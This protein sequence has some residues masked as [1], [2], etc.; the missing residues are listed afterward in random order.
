MATETSKPV[1]D[2]EPPSIDEEGASLP[3]LLTDEFLTRFER[4]VENYK[5]WIKACYKLT[6]ESHWLRRK[7]GDK[8][9]YMLQGPGAEAL[10][11]PL[12][13]SAD[14]PQ[15]TREVVRGAENEKDFYRYW[16]EGLVESK[17]LKRRGLY[18]GTCDSRDPFFNAQKHWSPAT[19]EG[20][21]KKSAQ[22]N[23]IVNAVSRLAGI[24]DPSEETLKDAGLNVEKIPTIDYDDTRTA[25][26]SANVI[27][28]AQ[29]GRLWAIMKSKKVT[30]DQVKKL[31]IEKYQIT[32]G[33]TGEIKR[34]DYEAICAWAEAGGT[35]EEKKP[36]EKKPE[37]EHKDEKKSD[38]LPL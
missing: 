31:L 18:I 25:E 5:R 2:Q 24:R 11:N 23:W 13:I 7:V 36:E 33:S 38:Q 19:G 16:C 15:F 17:A 12:A 6:N 29:R 21:V 28:T 27:T 4:G 30:E 3:A 14:E 32:S 26:Q 37:P 34:K 35:V 9:K 10:M 1:I 20:D 8:Y 22:T